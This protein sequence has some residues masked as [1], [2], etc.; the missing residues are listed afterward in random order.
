MLL[1]PIVVAEPELSCAQAG[2]SPLASSLPNA[3]APAKLL[4]A[5]RNSPIKVANGDRVCEAEAADGGKSVG[6][7]EAIR[8]A[9]FVPLDESPA[10]GDVDGGIAGGGGGEESEEEEGEAALEE[11]VESGGEEEERRMK[12]SGLRAVGRLFFPR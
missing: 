5:K 8:G 2:G 7:D 12:G 3:S 11:H 1:T 10:G 4:E 6:E 9:P